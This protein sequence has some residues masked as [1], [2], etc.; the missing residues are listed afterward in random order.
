MDGFLYT[1]TTKG[2]K[3]QYHYGGN[4]GVVLKFK[5]ETEGLKIYKFICVRK[6]YG[7]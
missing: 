5:G 3:K 2:K 6:E 1:D 7:R 4:D